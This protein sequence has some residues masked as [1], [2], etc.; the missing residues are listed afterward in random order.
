[1]KPLLTI[2]LVLCAFSGSGWA[3]SPGSV[4][5]SFR[6]FPWDFKDENLYLLSEGQYQP[7]IMAPSNFSCLY[8]YRG[9]SPMRLYHQEGVSAE[10]GK[11]VYEPVGSFPVRPGLGECVLFL[12]LSPDSS[13]EGDFYP[14]DLSGY[15]RGSFLVFNFTSEPFQMKSGEVVTH[16]DPL[17][18]KSLDAGS[19]KPNREGG[20]RCQIAYPSGEGWSLIYNKMAYLLPGGRVLLFVKSQREGSR[21]QVKQVR[22]AIVNDATRRSRDMTDL[23]ELDREG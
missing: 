20:F 15:G 7:L 8:T 14:L 4:S 3:E 13:I 12:F 9:P 17:E 18:L 2:L 1:M 11:P 19:I 10:T 6:V 22:D 5:I 16:I 21:L 23:L